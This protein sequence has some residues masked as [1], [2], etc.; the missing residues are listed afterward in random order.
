[1]IFGTLAAITL[2]DHHDGREP[3]QRTFLLPSKAGGGF[4]SIVKENADVIKHLVVDTL[5]VKTPLAGR[6]AK[7]EGRVVN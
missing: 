4:S 7:E 3:I 2:S 1:M 6:P 5:T